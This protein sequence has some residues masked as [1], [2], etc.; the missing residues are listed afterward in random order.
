MGD[1]LKINSINIPTADESFEEKVRDIGDI[2]T[3]FSGAIIRSRR[4]SKRDLSFQT[5]FL[6]SNED[7]AWERFLRGE[8][9]FFSFANLYGSKGTAPDAGYTGTVETANGPSGARNLLVSSGT[10]V[11]TCLPSGSPWTVS[12]WYSNNATPGTGYSYYTVNSASQKWV[13]GS[14]NDAA[15]TAFY[16]VSGGKV[17]LTGGS[18][19]RFAYIHVFPWTTPTSWPPI[20]FSGDIAA[21]L[22]AQPQLRASG[23]AIAAS[24]TRVVLGQVEVNSARIGGANTV[25][26]LR[27]TLTE[28]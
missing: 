11:Y 24:G 7:A 5:T 17:T 10:H 8:G 23:D 3:A 19:R 18:N 26:K 22:V 15:S 12:L 27:V 1:W 25:R 28:S 9:E 14:R 6:E 4:T 16:S 2:T 13:N 21:G 20:F